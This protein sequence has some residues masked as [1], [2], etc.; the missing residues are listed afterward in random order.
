MER[1]RK[2]KR[3]A[4]D[5]DYKAHSPIPAWV[6]PNFGP[7]N[8]RTHHLKQGGTIRQGLK[9]APWFSIYLQRVTSSSVRG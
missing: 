2:E 8:R 6:R 9:P 1:L 7:G 5:K 3:K 4:K